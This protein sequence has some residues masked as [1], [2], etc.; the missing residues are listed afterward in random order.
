MTGSDPADRYDRLLDPLSVLPV[1][2]VVDIEL[3]HA[4]E[5]LVRWE[6]PLGACNRPFGSMSHALC[7]EGEPVAVTVAASTVSSTVAGFTRKQV[8]ELA[9]IGRG[10]DAPWAMRPMVRL[11]R[12]VLA[13]RWSY[14]PVQAAISYAIPG[15]PGDIY[16]F[17]GWE[18]V[19]TVK[20]SSPGRNSTWSKPSASD[21]IGDGIKTLWRFVYPQEAVA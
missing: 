12:A 15:T 3:A 21:E 18:R 11:W 5:L 17:D 4:N 16:R 6:H 10:L 20:R 7:V 19:K 9:R 1:M 8:V 14:W 13:H 2:T